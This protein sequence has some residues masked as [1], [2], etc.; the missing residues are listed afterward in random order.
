MDHNG[1]QWPTMDHK[2]D[3]SDPNLPIQCNKY[4][5]YTKGR[6]ADGVEAEGVIAS[7]KNIL[8]TFFRSFY[9]L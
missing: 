5:R 6:F 3:R 1:P 9:F 8:Q 7:P 4:Q 2:V